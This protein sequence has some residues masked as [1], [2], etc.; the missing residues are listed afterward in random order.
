MQNSSDQPSDPHHRRYQEYEDPHFHDDDSE[1]ESSEDR[2]APIN[3]PPGKR[4]SPRK[5]PP[6]RWYDD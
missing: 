5:L 1:S 6:R 2:P 4:N 3:R